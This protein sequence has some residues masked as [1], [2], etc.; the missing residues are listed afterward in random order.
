MRNL[1]Y[2]AD[3]KSAPTGGVWLREYWCDAADKNH[4]ALRA[5]LLKKEGSLGRGVPAVH[6]RVTTRV[7][8]TVVC[9]Y[10]STGV[11][12]QIR[13]T[14]PFG[15]PSLKR[16]GVWVEVFLRFVSGQG[17]RVTPTIGTDF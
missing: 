8:P 17:Q 16:R 2:G 11:M 4:P 5:P 9:G 7:A 3:M 15:H 13:T 1:F 10:V 6:I 12:L 14:P